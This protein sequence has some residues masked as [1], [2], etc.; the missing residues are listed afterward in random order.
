[1]A[2]LDLERTVDVVLDHFLLH[3]ADVIDKTR[4]SASLQTRLLWEVVRIRIF[5]IH[6]HSLISFPFVS[7]DLVSSHT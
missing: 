1:M 7:V 5:S 3:L 4:S 2:E 6:L